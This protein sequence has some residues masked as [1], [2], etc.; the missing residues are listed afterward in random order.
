MLKDLHRNLFSDTFAKSVLVLSMRV[1]APVFSLED[2]EGPLDLLLHLIENKELDIYQV[3][4]E[5][6]LS[7]YQN[8]LKTLNQFDLDL[9]AEFLSIVSSLMLLKSKTLLPKQAATEGEID[10]ST[11]RVDII[12]QLIHYYKFKNIAQTLAEKEDQQALRYL[13]GVD[14][15]SFSSPA[16]AKLKS[17]PQSM[18]SELFIKVLE[19]QKQSDLK[20]IEEEDYKISDK[21]KEFKKN[22][23]ESNSLNF[24]NIFSIH[25]PKGELIALFIA[26]LEILKQGLASLD[27][28]EDQWVIKKSQG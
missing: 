27:Q 22:L 26:L 13:R 10:A 5:Q 16:E 9:G 14:L 18:L 11:L 20:F 28:S 23:L 2:F 3:I 12:E 8:Y 19:R 24:H 21:I 15:Q 17:T 6:V 25:K 1:S 7:Q 4:I